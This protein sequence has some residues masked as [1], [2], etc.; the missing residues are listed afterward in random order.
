MASPASGKACDGGHED[1][2][3]A[4]TAAAVVEELVAPRISSDH[5]YALAPTETIVAP[6]PQLTTV[7]EEPKKILPI[8]QT[9]KRARPVIRIQLPEGCTT[10]DLRVPGTWEDIIRASLASTFGDSEPVSADFA[11]NPSPTPDDL[12][13]E[14]THS[15]SSET[16]AFLLSNDPDLDLSPEPDLMD[17]AEF[18]RDT[19][20]WG[21]DLKLWS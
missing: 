9:V 11:L 14:S 21:D 5:V 18:D 10:L 7:V 1:D 15:P 2:S 20:P 3:Q 8:L 16:E 6:L 4:E 17:D 12:G 19:F 13:Y